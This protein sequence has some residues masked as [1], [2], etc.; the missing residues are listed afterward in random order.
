MKIIKNIIYSLI[1]LVK[2]N[3]EISRIINNYDI[4]FPAKWFRYFEADYE[5]ENILFL[6]KVCKKDMTIM[7]IGAHLGIM[8]VI[9]AKLIG[10]NGK[11]LSYEP[12][13]KTFTLLKKSL[14]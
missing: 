4:L 1:D 12:I 2:F 8:S 9:M 7:D 5:K 13:P 11:A 6:T 14:L 3:K 10:N